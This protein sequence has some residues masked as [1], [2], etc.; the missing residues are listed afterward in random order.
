MT[1]P[2]SQVLY[3]SLFKCVDA[4]AISRPATPLQMQTTIA[5]YFFLVRGTT[6]LHVVLV[7]AR[8]RLHSFLLKLQMIIILILTSKKGARPLLL[9][10]LTFRRLM[11]P[12]RLFVCAAALLT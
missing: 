10:I 8:A 4:Q 5:T 11:R 3:C 1:G 12:S 6:A 9:Q 2:N 7:D